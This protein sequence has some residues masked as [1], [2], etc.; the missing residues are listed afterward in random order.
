MKM[1]WTAGSGSEVV[2]NDRAVKPTDADA[3][4]SP[5][6]AAICDTA[7]PLYFQNTQ[8]HFV[9]TSSSYSLERPTLILASSPEGR[10]LVTYPPVTGAGKSFETRGHVAASSW[11]S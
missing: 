2:A 8:C 1:G 3:D 10:H 9:Q 4:V 7:L 11:K 6:D 5:R